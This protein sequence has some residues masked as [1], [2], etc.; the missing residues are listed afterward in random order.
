MFGM[1]TGISL[2]L[3]TPRKDSKGEP[4]TNGSVLESYLDVRCTIAIL[5]DSDGFVNNFFDEIEHQ[6]LVKSTPSINFV[7]AQDL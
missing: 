7:Q 4:N 2:A 1:G 6:L 5:I 3:W